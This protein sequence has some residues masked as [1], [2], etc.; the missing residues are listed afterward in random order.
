MHRPLK[1][2]VI[3]D[4]KTLRQG[5]ATTL[6]QDEGIVTVQAET[7]MEGAQ[8]AIKERR[9]V[10]LIDLSL[11]DAT[12]TDAVNVMTKLLPGAT[13]VVIT[14][15]DDQNLLDSAIRNGA[16][17]VIQKGSPESYGQGLI[18]AVRHAVIS[19]ETKI[20]AAPTH[21]SL[22]EAK[23]L[24]RAILEQSKPASTSAKA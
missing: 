3:E 23:T 4:D 7:L 11:A 17:K 21:E 19:H 2:I 24:V 14:G 13:I 10:A 16:H 18:D 8:L 15:S 5:L 22:G 12:G 20:M 9:V 1:V 6:E